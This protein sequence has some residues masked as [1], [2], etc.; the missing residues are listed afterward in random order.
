[1]P[2]IN[3]REGGRR[4]RGALRVFLATGLLGIGCDW[5]GVDYGG[6]SRSGCFGVSRKGGTPRCVLDGSCRRKARVSRDPRPS[7]LP[8][9]PCRQDSR[10]RGPGGR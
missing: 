9:R 5:D 1:M 3:P 6:D 7:E 8:A 2:I 10:D 4:R